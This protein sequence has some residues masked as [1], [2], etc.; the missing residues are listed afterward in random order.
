MKNRSRKVV[1]IQDD[2]DVEVVPSDESESQYVLSSVSELFECYHIDL[3]FR[4]NSLVTR[5]K[6]RKMVPVK[7]QSDSDS[8]EWEQPDTAYVSS[9]L[10]LQVFMLTV[11]VGKKVLPRKILTN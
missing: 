8:M 1:K 4:K 5:L 11:C 9:S 2:S 7:A 6:H 3:C 10:L